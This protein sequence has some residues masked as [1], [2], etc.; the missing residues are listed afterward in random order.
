MMKIYNLTI[1][2]WTLFILSS[3]N[4]FLEEKPDIKMVVPKSLNDAELLINDYL[5]MNNGY[6]LYGEWGTDEFTVTNENF[7]GV[8]NMDQRNI[9]TWKDEV[10]TDIVQWQRPYKVV[11]NANQVLEILD[12]LGDI[13]SDAKSKNFS[14]IAHFYRAFAFQQLSEVFAPAYQ[15]STANTEMGIPLRLKPGIDEVS[16]RATLEQSFD[17]II[18]DYKIAA[19]QLP[20]NETIN[21]RPFRSSAYAGLA[22]A[23]LYMGDYQMAYTYADSCLQ[24]HNELLDYNNLRASDDLPFD[25]FNVEVLFAAVSVNSGPMSL[26][27]GLV[28]STLYKSYTNND[29][30]KVIYFRKNVYPQDTYGFKGN[31]DKA[32]AT[33]FLGLTTSEMYLIKAEAAVRLGNITEA[34]KALNTL[35][36][37]RHDKNN[38]VAVTEINPDDLL[39]LILLERQKELLFRGRRWSDLKRL[40][41]DP[42]FKKILT[43]VVHGIGYKLEPNNRKYA[44][45]LPDPVVTIGKIPQNIR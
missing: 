31:Y 36:K 3:C 30:R 5:T 41:L 10:Y 45:R 8:M 20:L 2:I 11:Y 26:N 22:R 25:K 18:R 42:R 1:S 37:K 27:N 39:P 7:D 35:L 32:I 29:L 16:V 15:N 21:G 17:Q 6:P 9:Y 28:D 33:V 13:D 23:Y 38:Y 40:N 24:T 12:N 14:G 43:K 34:L 44:F 4:S 19:N